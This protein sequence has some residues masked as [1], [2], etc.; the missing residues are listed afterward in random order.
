MPRILNKIL[1]RMPGYEKGL[2]NSLKNFPH[3][4]T[5]SKVRKLGCPGPTS[6]TNYVTVANLNQNL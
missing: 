1:F 3:I 2:R 4:G 5:K 6:V